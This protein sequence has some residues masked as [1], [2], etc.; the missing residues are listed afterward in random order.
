MNSYLRWLL[1]PKAP[2]PEDV[3]E[4]PHFF[5]GEK[6]MQTSNDYE[7]EVFNGDMGIVSDILPDESFIFNTED[8]RK[9]EMNKSNYSN[10]EYGY[11]I[12]I[13]K[14]QGSEKPIVIIPVSS[15]HSYTLNRNLIYTGMTRAK[16][17]LILIGEKKAMFHAVKKLSQK[18][19]I[20]GLVDELRN[21]LP[22]I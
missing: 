10:L 21:E 17:K 2:A 20:T 9:I 11:A 8:G 7:L 12:S 6:V 3:M 5:D 4:M 13:H 19:R 22:Q 16:Q 15:V 1:N 18:L 14:S